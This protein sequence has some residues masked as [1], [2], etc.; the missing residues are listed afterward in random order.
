MVLR[1]LSLIVTSSLLVPVSAALSG[2]VS[3]PTY[4]ESCSELAYV[5]KID[6]VILIKNAESNKKD[7]NR[8]I[9]EQFKSINGIDYRVR[10]P[11]QH[12]AN[13]C[14]LDNAFGSLYLAFVSIG[15]HHEDS[16]IGQR[17]DG[18]DAREHDGLFDNLSDT[19]GSGSSTLERKTY[20]GWVR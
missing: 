6:T 7:R 12:Y 20:I 9:L 14:V 13:K 3:E 18:Q 10:R 5:G 15:K 11:A 8:F 4:R 2:P 17:H 19:T 1:K 16:S